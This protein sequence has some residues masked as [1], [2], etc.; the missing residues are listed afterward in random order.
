MFFACLVIIKL[1]SKNISKVTLT[2]I[3]RAKV[4]ETVVKNNQKIEPKIQT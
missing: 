4:T 1:C 3:A 2:P